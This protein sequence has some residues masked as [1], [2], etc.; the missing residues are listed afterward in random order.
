MRAM[1]AAPDPR[2][3]ATFG[4]CNRCPACVY[5][6]DGL[7]GVPAEPYGPCTADLRCPECGLEIPRGA[8]C[9]VGSSSLAAVDGRSSGA[10][11][12][13]GLWV[14]GGIGVL[15]MAVIGWLATGVGP[16]ASPMFMVS[17]MLG[18]AIGFGAVLRT[19][20]R[21]R[22]LDPEGAL[23]GGDV[24]L[25]FE[26][27]AL[28]VFAGDRHAPPQACA[29]ADVQRVMAANAWRFFPRPNLPPVAML[30]VQVP[31]QVM[32]RSGL[33]GVWGYVLLPRGRQAQDLAAELAA[34]LR[35]APGARAAV[36]L[37]VNA[38]TPSAPPVCPRCR[39]SLADQA[40]AQGAW[41]EPLGGPVRCAACGLVVPEGSFVLTGWTGRFSGAPSGRG[42]TVAVVA[43]VLVLA[44]L[45]VVL[46]GVLVR[47]TEL[48]FALPVL[49]TLLVIAAPRLVHRLLPGGPAPRP[50]GR[51]QPAPAALVV[52]PGF[53][54]L[55]E[56]RRGRGAR[57]VR[58]PAAGVSR[59]EFGTT[60][61]ENPYGENP[62]SVFVRGTAPA[63][64]VLGT[65][66]ITVRTHAGVDRDALAAD[67]NR[68]LRRPPASAPA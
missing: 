24:R 57:E 10:R 29:G 63:L 5:P 50:A 28:R 30:R 14:L 1:T 58:V 51:F 13:L 56:M 41:R 54:T 67:L 31:A 36:P 3:T 18:W 25:L 61:P 12:M 55:L 15:Q 43:T 22:A 8:R 59:I 33:G 35:A 23:G 4:A 44:F 27:G 37:V 52:E 38:P 39:A 45:G 68:A 7:P 19:H 46:A 17:A 64:G 65:L 26:P 2:A 42:L 53:V 48:I 6:L 21:Q 32:A 11:T 34:T 16:L 62:D 66:S 60:D 9:V 49:M 47:R 40:A 20:L